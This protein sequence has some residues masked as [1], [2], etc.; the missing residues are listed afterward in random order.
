MAETPVI[1]IPP[2]PPPEELKLISPRFDEDF[3]AMA[4]ADMNE[5]LEQAPKPNNSPPKMGS[6]PNLQRDAERQQKQSILDNDQKQKEREQKT[7]WGLLIGTQIGVATISALIST[8][9]LYIVNPPISQKKTQDNMVS[10]GQDWK[11]VLLITLIVFFIVLFIPTFIKF[12]KTGYEFV[13][14]K[15]EEK[16]QK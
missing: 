11:K 4:F 8:A 2:P 13:L 16:Q 1:G 3:G 15:R 10:E 14:K 9:L 5:K 12:F 6:P 7:A